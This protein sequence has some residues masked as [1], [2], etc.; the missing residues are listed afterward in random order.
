MKSANDGTVMS[1]YSLQHRDTLCNHLI[2]MSVG[3]QTDP[4]RPF[5]V[6]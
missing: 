6:A 5:R 4:D 2:Y 3:P 1:V